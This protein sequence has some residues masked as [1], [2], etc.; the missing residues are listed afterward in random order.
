MSDKEIIDAYFADPMVKEMMT[1]ELGPQGKIYVDWKNRT[2][3]AQGKYSHKK[4][5]LDEF[6]S[7]LRKGTLQ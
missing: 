7:D 6:V 1:A 3:V 2:I 4:W 5:N